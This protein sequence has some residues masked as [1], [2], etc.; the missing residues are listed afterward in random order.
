MEATMT[1][2]STCHGTGQRVVMR[3]VIPGAKIPPYEPCPDC[4][5]TG[6]KPSPAERKQ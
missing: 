4:N 3:T 2:C 6:Q 5:G 1:T